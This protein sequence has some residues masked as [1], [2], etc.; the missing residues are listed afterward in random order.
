MKT[1]ILYSELA[2]LTREVTCSQIYR[3][4]KNITDQKLLVEH[5][6]N[7]KVF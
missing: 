2:T 5:T 3:H 4:G 6:L 1:C 7:S